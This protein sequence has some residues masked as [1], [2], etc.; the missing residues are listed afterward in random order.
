M[1]KKTLK[2]R[3]AEDLN[4]YIVEAKEGKIF[5]YAHGGTVIITPF[6]EE[7]LEQL[8]NRIFEL[9]KGTPADAESVLALLKL[10]LSEKKEN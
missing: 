3:F 5:V 9:I 6:G 7:N 1:N 8:R 4:D 2:V 10:T